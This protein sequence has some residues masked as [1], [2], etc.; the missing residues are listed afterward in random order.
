M[1]A[2]VTD[3]VALSSYDNGDLG[4]KS[5]TGLTGYFG[6]VT[7]DD[8]EKNVADLKGKSV[9][10]LPRQTPTFYLY[11][12]LKQNGLS[13]SDVTIK[14]VPPIPALLQIV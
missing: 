13:A 6:N 9:A 1:D 8:S 4:W 5:A 3:V 10:T 12:Q 11:Q 14:E 2:D 7:S